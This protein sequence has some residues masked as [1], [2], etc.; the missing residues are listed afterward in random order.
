MIAKTRHQAGLRFTE[1]AGQDE[2]AALIPCVSLARMSLPC[3]Y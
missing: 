3:M 1:Q 2:L